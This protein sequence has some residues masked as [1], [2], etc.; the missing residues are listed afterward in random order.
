MS[1]SEAVPHTPLDQSTGDLPAAGNKWE[2]IKQFA[3]L[4]VRFL[5]IAGLGYLSWLA[6]YSG[7]LEL[8]NANNGA[9][10]QN[11]EIAIGFAT[12]ML[13]LIIIYL[14]DNL[15]SPISWWL[16]IFYIAGYAFL[17]II[18]VGFGFGFYWKYLESRA[19]ATRSAVSAVEQVETA[20][21]VGGIRLEQVQA[22]FNSL[23][24][25]S[26]QKAILERTVGKTC[27]NSPPG[28]GPR[29]RLRDADARNFQYAGEFVKRRS[30]FIQKD[31]HALNSHV[32]AIR[33]GA[34]GTIDPVSNTRNI[35]LQ[36]VNHKLNLTLTRFNTFRTDPQLIQF[37]NSF[38]SRA[39][40][41]RFD[42]GKGGT[43]YCPDAQLGIALMGVVK[44]I[45]ELPQL[46]N[47]E[48]A[49]V[50]GSEAIVE[51]FRRLTTSV[52]GLVMPVTDANAG[53]LSDRDYIPLFIALFVDLCLL[54]ISVNRPVNR[55][56]GFLHTA[57][58]AHNMQMHQVLRRFHDVHE[59]KRSG[60]LDVFHDVMFDIGVNQY[61]AV[62]ID[63]RVRPKTRE[64]EQDFLDHKKRLTQARYLATLMT[65][66]EEAGLVYRTSLVSSRRARRKLRLL[67]SPYASAPG[68]RVYRFSKGAWPAIIL[69]D[70]LGESEVLQHEK[71]LLLPHVT[72]MQ[73]D[74][75]NTNTK[76]ILPEASEETTMNSC[77][78]N[79]NES[80]E[81]FERI[82]K[83]EIETCLLDVSMNQHEKYSRA[84]FDRLDVAA[85]PSNENLFHHQALYSS[86]E[87]Y[88]IEIDKIAQQFAPNGKSN[89]DETNK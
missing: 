49:A 28:D 55:L 46:P 18:S 19:E 52:T 82:M 42:D 39:K 62:P 17:T 27:P 7:M 76:E 38:E 41:A 81:Q 65:T 20:L 33:S 70:I 40:Q 85:K 84:Q 6:T 67:C 88:P 16:R 51:A 4:L 32:S 59:S 37:R 3:P 11:Y 75:S 61:V 64:N 9:V 34:P 68:F 2:H 23:M 35:F 53:G 13:M 12:V 43:F 77:H 89:P 45:D 30:G 8:I 44:A 63:L 66:L 10:N 21:T 73:E 14:L 24:T 29:R 56:Q 83:K 15:F 57:R 5:L 22:T 48:I 50:E 69:D 1:V 87:S 80:S 74:N 54:L 26:T 60:R 25:I 31:I 78:A 36:K 79:D 47:T 86:D 71:R 58:K 72:Q